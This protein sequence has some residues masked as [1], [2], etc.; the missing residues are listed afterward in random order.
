M[1][2]ITRCNTYMVKFYDDMETRSHTTGFSDHTTKVP[3][4]KVEFKVKSGPRHGSPVIA[5]RETR[6]TRTWSDNYGLP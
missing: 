4:Y 3:M 1:A 2:D 6:I 5:S